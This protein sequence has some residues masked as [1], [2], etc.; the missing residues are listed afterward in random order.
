MRLDPGPRPRPVRR[1]IAIAA[2]LGNSDQ[3][4]HAV[5]DFAEAY[6][7]QNERDHAALAEAVAWQV[8]CTGVQHAPTSPPSEACSQAVRMQ[9]GGA[10]YELDQS[11]V[12]ADLR[13]GGVTGAAP[14]NLMCW[15]DLD[16]G[17]L[18]GPELDPRDVLRLI[19][20]VMEI[21]GWSAS[22]IGMNAVTA[23][24]PVS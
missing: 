4:D 17:L 23:V 7:D 21:R 12:F 8:E 6:A 18:V 22:T 9:R 14:S 1:P 5:A 20:R 13:P 24:P 16:V 15:R 3:F 19:S 2:Y 11:G 10:S